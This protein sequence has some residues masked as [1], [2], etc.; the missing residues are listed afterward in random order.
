PSWRSWEAM[1]M[2]RPQPLSSI[3]PISTRVHRNTARR[4]T[5][6]TRSQSATGMSWSSDWVKI[7]AL[8]TRM[9]TGPRPACTCSA[10]A[11]TAASSLMSQ[12]TNSPRRPAASISARTPAACSGPAW[13]TTATSAP[14]RANPAAMPCPIPDAAP[15]TTATLPSSF[16][17]P[18]ISTGYGSGGAGPGRGGGTTA[19]AGPHVLDLRGGGHVEPVPHEQQRRVVLRPVV[20]AHAVLSDDHIVVGEHRIP[21]RRFDAALRG[22]AAHDHGRDAVAA[23]QQLQVGAPERAGP[24]LGH[25]QLAGPGRQLG[26]ERVPRRARHGVPQRRPA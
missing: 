12:R 15:V 6:S 24:V 16:P 1:L 13:S 19:A 4:L 18:L 26:H 8:L 23:Q 5:F 11:R 14:S 21:G 17:M 10:M 20:A 9:S 2:I 3:G 25:H 7:P 22:A